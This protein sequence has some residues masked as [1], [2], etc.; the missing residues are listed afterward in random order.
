MDEKQPSALRPV[1]DPT[2]EFSD[3]E[4]FWQ[5]HWKKFAAGLAA[6]VLAI[7]AVGAWMLWQSS[8]RSAAEDAY[9]NA[10]GMEA[11]RGVIDN[12]PRTI[13]AGNARLRIADALREQGDTDGAIA[14]LEK[15]TSDQPEHPLA[16]AA[17]LM[18]G[19][20]RQVQGNKDLA[21]D[22]FRRSSGTYKDSYTAPLAMIS[23]AELLASQ[24]QTGEARAIL[25][26][27]GKLYP[28]TP[29]AM[30]A[31]G[32][33]GRLPPAGATPA[34]APPPAPAEAPAQP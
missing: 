16:G 7:L 4:L 33:A 18:I 14:E 32:E 9:S 31:G 27:I 34:Q 8:Q 22:A 23:E 10:T 1:L 11:W 24:G 20:L 13:P 6:I 25:E 3:S 2:I 29:A 19:Q 21:L 12:F 26:S 30:I 15:L 17:W 28:E 5:E